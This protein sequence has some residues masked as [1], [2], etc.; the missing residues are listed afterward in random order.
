M[1]NRMIAFYCFIVSFEKLSYLLV[2]DI[3]VILPLLYVYLHHTSLQTSDYKDYYNLTSTHSTPM[4]YLMQYAYVEIQSDNIHYIINNITK[5]IAVVSSMALRQ[6]SGSWNILCDIYY[7]YI[8][9]YVYVYYLPAVNMA[10]N[11]IDISNV[12]FVWWFPGNRPFRWS[13]YWLFSFVW[14][15]SLGH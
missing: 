11:K 8:H 4:D 7:I 13:C 3:I 2:H 9:V 10:V 6:W 15:P 1:K 14:L 12:T 5:L